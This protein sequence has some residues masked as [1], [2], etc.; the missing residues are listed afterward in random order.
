MTPLIFAMNG[1]HVGLKL[2]HRDE[3]QHTDG[4]REKLRACSSTLV[5]CCSKEEAMCL[6]V[7]V[8]GDE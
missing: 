8:L 3:K 5:F 7:I 2:D 4:N 1:I 6:S